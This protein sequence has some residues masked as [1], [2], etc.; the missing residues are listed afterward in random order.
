MLTYGCLH[1]LLIA[2]FVRE[3]VGCGD[4]SKWITKIQD[5][6]S[7]KDSLCMCRS[8]SPSVYGNCRQLVVVVMELLKPRA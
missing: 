3:E 7:L 8:E 5:A 2:S 1:S 6:P 4:I